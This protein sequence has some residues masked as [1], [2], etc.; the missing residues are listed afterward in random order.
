MKIKLLKKIMTWK[1][2]TIYSIT[3]ISKSTSNNLFTKC[4]TVSLPNIIYRK[5]GQIY[6]LFKFM[7]ICKKVK[8]IPTNTHSFLNLTIQ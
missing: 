8:I 1:H 3:L 6:L 4:I 2:E 5:F 7:N